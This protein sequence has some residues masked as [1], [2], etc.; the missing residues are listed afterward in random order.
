[1]FRS[2]STSALLE[3][4]SLHSRLEHYNE[5]GSTEHLASLLEAGGSY[6]PIKTVSCDNLTDQLN[7]LDG[8]TY[9]LTNAKSQ[10]GTVFEEE[11]YLD[12]LS[13]Q[14]RKFES[15]Q[16]L[17]HFS[18]AEDNASL[19]SSVH[20]RSDESG[21]ESDGIKSIH[22]EFS[23]A[24]KMQ[25]D[26]NM[27]TNI[28]TSTS[29]SLMRIFRTNEQNRPESSKENCMY[30]LRETSDTNL[31]IFTAILQKFKSQSSIS[32]SVT[33]VGQIRS[34]STSESR[35]SF[36][37]DGDVKSFRT[38]GILSQFILKSKENTSVSKSE[39]VTDSVHN[40]TNYTETAKN[41]TKKEPTRLGHFK[42]WT[43]DRKLL[44][45]R[46][47]KRHN[48]ESEDFQKIES[49][50]PKRTSIFTSLFFETAQEKR[51]NSNSANTSR[52]LENKGNAEEETSKSSLCGDLNY[53]LR[54]KKAGHKTA[55]SSNDIRKQWLHTRWCTESKSEEFASKESALHYEES[56]SSKPVSSD[57][58]VNL[59]RPGNQRYSVSEY[60]IEYR[61]L[62]ITLEKDEQGELGIYIRRRENE[63][64]AAGYVIV[65]LEK[66]GPADRSGQLQKGDELL[67]INDKTVQGVDLKEAQ[68]LLQTF[69]TSVNLVVVRKVN[70][71]PHLSETS[72][73]RNINNYSKKTSQKLDVN[74]KVNKYHNSEYE[75]ENRRHYPFL[76]KRKEPEN[77]KP[78]NSFDILPRRPNS[79][80]LSVYT[81]TFQKGPG[82][83]SLGFSIV[84]GKD[85]PKG[86]MGIFVK[87]IFPTGQAAENGKLKEGD[88]MLMINDQ[89]LQGMSHAEAIVAFK[90]I[91]QGEFFLQVG[92]RTT[93][94]K[95]FYESKSC[96]NLESFP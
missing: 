29:K 10:L 92:R 85:S 42:A 66:D 83:K 23:T 40:V 75:R 94:Q 71:E 65:A 49:I 20:H 81:M 14:S 74:S 41:V 57:P 63:G 64:D 84:G 68:R 35:A 78:E 9:Q 80:H 44:R 3:V 54:Q 12:N 43:L 72:L 17:N 46:W 89:S 55:S 39:R 82:C 47:K 31:Q 90:Q 26:F 79:S 37:S 52:K 73:V 91:K 11:V 32:S 7:P 61:T 13:R 21:Y 34:R 95:G 93:S 2:I 56:F 33:S 8:E 50:S 59:E 1:M 77:K 36:K 24:E 67:M 25:P 76:E 38:S 60:Y 15:N 4:G 53:Q 51:D 96:S 45:N 18:T 22:D 48:P 58:D 6:L 86:E 62:K 19:A 87:T 5:F 16:L 30:R 69:E 88:E 28:P 70:K 27:G